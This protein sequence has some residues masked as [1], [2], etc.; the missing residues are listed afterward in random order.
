ML[1]NWG[2]SYPVGI[3]MDLDVGILVHRGEGHAV[4]ELISQDP[5]VYHVVAECIEQFYVDIAH[6][7][8]QHFL[9]RKDIAVKRQRHRVQERGLCPKWAQIPHPSSM[10]E[11]SFSEHPWEVGG[12]WKAPG[13]ACF[14]FPWGGGTF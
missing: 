3:V 9:E 8:V 2:C 11:S 14:H 1:G 7:G 12:H 5:P 6:Q 10:E 13:E 4:L